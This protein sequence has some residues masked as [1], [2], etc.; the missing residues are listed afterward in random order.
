MVAEKGI[1]KVNV[2]DNGKCQSGQSYGIQT[3]STPIAS[4]LSSFNSS[5][6]VLQTVKFLATFSTMET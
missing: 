3:K 2:I 6:S 5:L 4:L 1:L